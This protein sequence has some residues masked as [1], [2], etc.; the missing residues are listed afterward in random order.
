[1]IRGFFM[2][3]LARIT[4]TLFV[5][6]MLASCGFFGGKD[7]SNA[8]DA[9][10]VSLQAQ[11]GGIRTPETLA[12]AQSVFA[13]YQRDV[14]QAIQI[15]INDGGSANTY[16]NGLS[17]WEDLQYLRQSFEQFYS[18]DVPNPLHN[19]VWFATA[20]LGHDELR[21]QEVIQAIESL[22]SSGLSETENH[23]ALA[24]EANCRLLLLESINPEL[25]LALEQK[26][27]AYEGSSLWLAYFYHDLYVASVDLEEFEEKSQQFFA[28]SLQHTDDTKEG[29]A[30]ADYFVMYRGY[31]HLHAGQFETA[32]Q[33]FKHVNMD[34]SHIDQAYLGYGW[35]ALSWSDPGLAVESWRQ[36]IYKG[37]DTP[38]VLEALLAIPFVLE[39]QN[40]NR[41]AFQ[42]YE[43]AVGR[44]QDA[45][46]DIETLRQWLS[47]NDI[48]IEYLQQ[49]QSDGF[50]FHY[51][52]SI[53]P[54]LAEAHAREDFQSLFYRMHLMNERKASV[55]RMQETLNI[56]YEAYQADALASDE[57]VD[58]DKLEKDLA[59]LLE[60]L[61]RFSDTVLYLVM[62][63][64]RVE[65]ELK[66]TYVK[67]IALKTEATKQGL[68][69]TLFKDRLSRLRGAML[70]QA[71]EVG[72]S[73]FIFSEIHQLA[74]FLETHRLLQDRYQRYVGLLRDNVQSAVIGESDISAMM[75][76]LEESQS[77]LD[78]MLNDLAEQVLKESYQALDERESLINGYH[79]HA[80]LAVTRFK[81]KF[82]YLG[83]RR[84]EWP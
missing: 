41:E 24:L 76:L 26:A 71:Y 80:K 4:S 48:T 40:A 54:I 8:D 16:V 65:D 58:L 37:Y 50:T 56:L 31:A 23:E 18:G 28:L 64:P 45:L 67:Y 78:V 39:K 36:L 13:F 72:G 42:A 68:D 5:V 38:I 10:F 29:Q 83:R 62:E 82:Y 51:G 33:A 49:T 21:C 12:V 74:R 69:E 47:E 27:Q 79:Y 46:A 53:D 32:V 17:R 20:R 60:T 84:L 55:G 25:L 44:Y 14:E 61:L 70:M 66:D 6:S 52:S 77:L 57:K 1:M 2:A 63:D 73:S 59:G 34:S 15:L 19:D 3:T 35:A 11:R 75:S 43:R 81:E 7:K 22:S 30:L 9:Q